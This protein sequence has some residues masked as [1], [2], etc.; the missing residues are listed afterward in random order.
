MIV[1]IWVRVYCGNWLAK[2]EESQGTAA[3][4]FEPHQSWS[5][6]VCKTEWE[7][8]MGLSTNLAQW[9]T[10]AHTHTHICAYIDGTEPSLGSTHS[11]LMKLME[12]LSWSGMSWEEGYGLLS[13]RTV[14][15]L[16][17]MQTLV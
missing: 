15:M 16:S 3:W 9:C 7:N 8:R 11:D 5:L 6:T 10:L 12:S 4:L 2:G 1:T 13:L 14:Q 17:G